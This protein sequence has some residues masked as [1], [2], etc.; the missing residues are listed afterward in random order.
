MR[1]ALA[2]LVVLPLAAFVPAASASCVV[3][4]PTTSLCW[5]ATEGDPD[6]YVVALSHADGATTLL[7]CAVASDGGEETTYVAALACL[8]HRHVLTGT[9]WG[10]AALVATAGETTGA[11]L[12]CLDAGNDNGLTGASSVRAEGTKVC[13]WV[14]G[15]GTCAGL[16]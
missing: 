2:F 15:V 7:A 14:S 3:V 8:S 5:S 16:V 12:V 4:E 10:C 9:T 11:R 6:Q 13:V 1:A